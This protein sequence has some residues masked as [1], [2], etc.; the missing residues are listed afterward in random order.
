MTIR[1]L[2]TA[3]EHG[4]VDRRNWT[5]E[6]NRDYHDWLAEEHYEEN[7]YISLEEAW[8]RA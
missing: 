1:E 6:E 7:R 5:S 8:D 2:E 4:H 3:L